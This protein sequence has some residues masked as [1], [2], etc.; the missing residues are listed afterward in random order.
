M[1]IAKENT[2]LLG[3]E[4]SVKSEMMEGA[5]FFVNIPFKPVYGTIETEE[6]NDKFII[7]IAEDEEVNYI[8][9]E[10]ILKDIMKLNCDILHAK[11]GR[12][13]VDICQSNIAIDI[14]LMDLKMPVL[15]GFLAT[16][17][18]RKFRPYLPIIAQTAYSTIEDRKEAI[19][20]GCNDFIS[21]PI[22]KEVIMN[23]IDNFLTKKLAKFSYLKHKSI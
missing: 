12:E 7:L 21:K 1:S 3:G 14:V 8:Y 13:A 2:E 9:L 4:I 23:V 5:T 19:N 22:E 18:I 10:T 15:N 20:I 16:K 17:Q 11:N 6:N